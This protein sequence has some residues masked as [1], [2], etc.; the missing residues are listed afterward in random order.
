MC[1]L[2]PPIQTV[3]RSVV[4][5]LSIAISASS[6]PQD[7]TFGK[8]FSRIDAGEV[9]LIQVLRNRWP[10][11]RPKVIHVLRNNS[12][13]DAWTAFYI[14]ERCDKPLAES[15]CLEFLASAKKPFLRVRALSYATEH[16]YQ[17][18]LPPVKKLLKEPLGPLVTRT[19]KALV[20]LDPSNAPRLI[21]KRLMA[22]EVPN[23]INGLLTF[24]AGLKLLKA[25]RD[26]SEFNDVAWKWRDSIRT[27]LEI[28]QSIN[29]LV[30]GDR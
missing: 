18:A 22:S 1:H 19:M 30:T 9:E 14:I 13:D 27:R 12:E 4:A 11:Y 7:I 20:V 3:A 26:Q 2:K 16:R 29:E 15:L 17:A 6:R 23:T 28:L 25:S 8:L 10:E 24:K 5:F 21:A